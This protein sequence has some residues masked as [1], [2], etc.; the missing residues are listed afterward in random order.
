MNTFTI[1]TVS[2]DGVDLALADVSTAG[3]NYLLQYGYTQ[4][5]QDAV[6]G[7]AKAVK[8]NPA[9][10]RKPSE[11]SLSIEALVERVLTDKLNERENAIVSGTIGTR[12]TGPKLSSLERMVQTVG[13]ERLAAAASA[14]GRKLPAVGSDQ[15]KNL[16]EAYIEKYADD[17]MAEAKTRIESNA[18]AATA[19]IDDLLD[20]LDETE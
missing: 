3:L 13:K 20:S 15:F 2:H 14:K 11:T 16:L 7:L 19:D 6:A 5:M 4:S 10:Y 1:E 8:G 17:V 9:K 18:D 12:K